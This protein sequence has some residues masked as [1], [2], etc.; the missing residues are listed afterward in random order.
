[1]RRLRAALGFA[2]ADQ[3]IVALWALNHQIRPPIGRRR[4]W[5]NG[6]E[7]LSCLLCH[8]TWFGDDGETCSWCENAEEDLRQRQADLDQRITALRKEATSG[9]GA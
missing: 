6:R 7:L 2:P 8:A 1:L 4:A 5:I 9:H 3:L